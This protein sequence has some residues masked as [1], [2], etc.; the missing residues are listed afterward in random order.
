MLIILIHANILQVYIQS[1]LP[2]A[3][4][5][6]RVCKNFTPQKQDFEGLTTWYCH[7][8]WQSSCMGPEGKKC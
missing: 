2:R 5:N 7:S 1:E 3:D 4:E 8:V 6:L